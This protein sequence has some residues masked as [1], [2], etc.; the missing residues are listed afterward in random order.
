M[1]IVN[2]RLCNRIGDEWL[3]DLLVTYVERDIFLRVKTEDVIQRFQNMKPRR[4]AL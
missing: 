4:I 2:N 3:N 1:N